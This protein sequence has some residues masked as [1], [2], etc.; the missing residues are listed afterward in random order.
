[1]GERRLFSARMLHQI[2][3]GGKKEERGEERGGGG[4][5]GG[6]ESQGWKRSNSQ[7]RMKEG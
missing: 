5:G 1:M 6:G 4:G 2:E 7:E 3:T